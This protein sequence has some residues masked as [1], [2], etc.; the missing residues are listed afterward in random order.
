MN[1]IIPIKRE[2]LIETWLDSKVM[3]C[4][5]SSKYD[6]S[7][8]TLKPYHSHY[9]KT[10]YYE[11]DGNDTDIKNNDMVYSAIIN[12]ISINE[13]ED[14]IELKKISKYNDHILLDPNTNRYHSN[15][16]FR[17]LIDFAYDNKYAYDIYDSE[18][19]I[20]EK[21]NIMDKSLKSTFYK[22]CYNNTYKK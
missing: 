14:D 12:S 20:T 8:Y 11:D 9:D 15:Y 13:L 18:S 19:G 6:I 3:D 21:F 16:L 22:F 17:Q 5:I 7:E 2:N 10:V 4:D 1:G